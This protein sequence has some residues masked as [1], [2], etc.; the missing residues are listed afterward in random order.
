MAK[1]QRKKQQKKQ[2]RELKQ[3]A[4]RNLQKIADQQNKQITTEMTC[5][6]M[7]YDRVDF[8]LELAE[9]GDFDQANDILSELR[10]KY[11]R[12]PDIQFG[13]GTLALHSKNTEEAIE[14]FDKAIA[15]NPQYINAHFNRAVAY[16]RQANVK[17]FVESLN[18][19]INLAHADAELAEQARQKLEDFSA[20][21]NNSGVT[22][23]QFI[24]GQKNFE[25]AFEYLEKHEFNK[26]IPFFQKAISINPDPPQPY[27]NLG[28]CYAC[29]GEI[30]T[31]LH[32][33]DKA[34]DI[35]PNYELA[36]LNRLIVKKLEKGEKL[37]ISE[38][39]TVNY[40]ADYFNR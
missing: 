26:A 31:A 19:V 4:K 36:A 27:G 29:L 13:L 16:Q 25:T 40:Y 5:K 30:E 1:D 9:D 14:H 21:F 8:A 33:F 2:Q 38:I 39:K 32:Y 12:N 15:I 35:D 22:L 3:K 24:E 17:G 7:I 10:K 23:N 6:K 20:S 11:S 37:A 28:I 18:N 34:L